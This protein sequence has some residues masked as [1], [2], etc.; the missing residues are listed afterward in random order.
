M[1]R[2]KLVK[3]TNN[4]D[5]SNETLSNATNIVV[6]ED[7]GSIVHEKGNRYV[8]NIGTIFGYTYSI[9][10]SII[11]FHKLNST[12]YISI[13]YKNILKPLIASAKSITGIFKTFIEL[14]FDDTV[15]ADCISY[16]DKQIVVWT[17]NVN[18][19]RYY[20]FEL[21]D[22]QDISINYFYNSNSNSYSITSS[23]SIA[24]IRADDYTVTKLSSNFW[25]VPYKNENIIL[26]IFALDGRYKRVL[27]HE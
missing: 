6:S 23:D 27:I 2:L 4:I 15:Q 12:Y 7:L 26:H 22:I 3:D 25:T 24:E 21:P 11:L 13:L 1:K 16:Q 9:D 14:R 18:P 20:E 5:T 10:N 19:I 17:D 8:D